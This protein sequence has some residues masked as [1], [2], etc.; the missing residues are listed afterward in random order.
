MLASPT[1]RW[2][3]ASS[4]SNLLFEAGAGLRR[5]I[6]TRVSNMPKNKGKGGKNRRRGKN[7]NDGD[8]REL[9]FKEFGQEYALV[10]KTLGGGHFEVQCFDGE[11]RIAH[12]RGKLRKKVE[13]NDE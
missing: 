3:R 8:K 4:S 1:S 7:E 10:G 6:L 12:V 11:K 9:I 2:I 5:F 13:K